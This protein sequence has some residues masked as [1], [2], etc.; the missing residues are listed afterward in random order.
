MGDLLFLS[1]IN[2]IAKGGVMSL[3]KFK[4]ESD[5]AEESKANLEK[6]S[7]AVNATEEGNDLCDI[8]DMV[9]TL[10]DEKMIFT[11][12]DRSEF[13]AVYRKK[14]DWFID[15]IKNRAIKILSVC[16]TPGD[17]KTLKSMLFGEKIV[18]RDDKKEIYESCDE[19][20]QQLSA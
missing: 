3:S 16:Q 20:Y 14:R 5:I 8:R 4:L 10:S 6:F 11:S 19:V 17:V 2:I 15:D 12:E 18:P 13:W 1:F 9:L 7:K